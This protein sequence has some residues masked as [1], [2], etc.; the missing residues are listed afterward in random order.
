MTDRVLLTTADH[1]PWT[2]RMARELTDIEST[3]TKVSLLYV[4]DEADRRSTQRNLN[5]EGRIVDTDELAT[6][7]EDVMRAKAVL[8][9]AGIEYEVVARVEEDRAEAIL[10]AAAAR[11]VDR[12]YVYSQGRNPVGKA[13]F[14]SELQ[15][16]IRW[17]SVPVIVTPDGAT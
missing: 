9:A 14:G 15:D 10:D 13:V 4:F 2:E 6:R 16:V 3:D 1:P 12:I 11:N 7:K 5:L 17:S 8:E